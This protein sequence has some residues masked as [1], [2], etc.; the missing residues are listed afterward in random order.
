[1]RIPILVT[2]L[3]L[4]GSRPALA[5]HGDHDHGDHDHQHGE[6]PVVAEEH[7]EPEHATEHAMTPGVLGL[8]MARHGS[9]TG[10]LPDQTP[11]RAVHGRAAGWDL[12]LHYN[13]F[14]GYDHQGTDA[15]DGA[16]VSQNWLMAMAGHA[17]GGG[18]IEARGMFSLEPLTVPGAGYPLLMQTGETF[19]GEPIVDRQHPHDLFMELAGIYRREL[20]GG[21]AVE[22]YAAL[23]GEPALGPVAFPHRFSSMSDPLAP[24]SHH[25]QDATHI[26]YGVLTAGV[27]TR[28]VKVEGSWFNGRE[29][30][31]NRWDMD[32]RTPDSFAARV[33]VNP[34]SQWSLQASTARLASPEALE[35]DQS[36][37]RW[38][39][40]ATHA[41][42]GWMATAAWGRNVPE[43]GPA[44]DSLL[45]ES[46]LELIDLG[47]TFARAEYVV[48]TGHDFGLAMEE[49]E[50]PLA[51]LSIGHVHPVRTIAGVETGLGAR[52]SLG[53]VDDDLEARYGTRTPYGAMIYLQV[54]PT[55][56][57]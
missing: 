20:A 35:P 46:A 12:M 24:L 51:N 41:A 11:V 25:W 48:K 28:K 17:L 50:L 54:Q 38:T 7:A 44:T 21:V 49:A 18:V 13:L 19:E 30:D 45:V 23:A 10:W 27:F 47:T 8:P 6:A 33:S 39:A 31:E 16:L 15:G 22:G 1:M 56:M 4:L 40:S 14:A 53:I 29:P 52:A 57:H 42:Q 26:S 9:G 37:Q 5:Q 3:G 55:P 2:T 36:V 43:H 32:L 34:R